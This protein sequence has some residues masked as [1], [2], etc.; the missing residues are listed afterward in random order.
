LLD[1]KFDSN[2]F[3]IKRFIFIIKTRLRLKPFMK[4]KD[5]NDFCVCL[6][7]MDF[8]FSRKNFDKIPE[9]NKIKS[10]SFSQKEDPKRINKM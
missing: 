9:S 8:I 7:S 4:V 2:Y 5:F 1:T 3:V 6:V 10:P